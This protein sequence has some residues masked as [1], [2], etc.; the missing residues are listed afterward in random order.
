MVVRVSGNEAMR[1]LADLDR[2]ALHGV[3]LRF[4]AKRNLAG[5]IHCAV[6]YVPVSGTAGAA[7]YDPV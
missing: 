4:K 2:A 5:L 3:A 1:H 6:C 7:D